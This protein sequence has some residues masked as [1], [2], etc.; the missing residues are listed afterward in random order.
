MKE[1]E[2]FGPDCFDPR[3]LN[4]AKKSIEKRLEI[5]NVNFTNLNT[6]NQFI[7]SRA[8]ELFL[9]DPRP[10]K[11]SNPEEELE[12]LFKEL[13]GGRTRAK[14]TRTIF[15]KLD[16][17]F[18]SPELVKRIQFNQFVSVPIVNK[19]IRI[20]Y[21]YRNGILNLVKP[22]LFTQD[23]IPTAMQLAVEGDLIQTNPENSE[24]SN[25]ILVPKFDN[26]IAKHS[27]L[28][29]SLSDLFNKYKIRTVWKEELYEF[30]E[31]VKKQAH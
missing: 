15:P 24:R 22:Q 26:K 16:R 14:L 1:C 10:L 18:R 11:L 29:R 31:E 4:L 28:R 27:S 23:R 9:T 25:F 2:F 8:N 21:A 19:H 12:K 20:P 17:V 6:L 3:R 5:E 30:M 7:N 13:V